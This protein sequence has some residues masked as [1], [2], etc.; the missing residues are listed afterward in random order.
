VP[1]LVRAMLRPVRGAIGMVMRESAL[2]GAR[3]TASTAAP[4]LLTIAFA[5]FIAGNVQTTTEAFASRRASLVQAGSVLVP[6]GT[7]GLSDAVARS[8][9]LPSDVYLRGTVTTALGLDPATG[10]GPARSLA[11]ADSAV[12]AESLA[13]RW[14]VHAGDTIEV[15]FAD[16][17]RV[18]LRITAVVPPGGVPAELM[19]N[20][21]AVRR[22][23]PSA[24]A[25]VVPLADDGSPAA[26]IGAR[27]TATA[28]YARQADAE[29]DRL[30]WI[31]TLLLVAV[32]VGYGGLAVANTLFMATARRAPDYRLLRLAG[33]TPRQVLLAVAGESALA[34]SVG[35]VL[36][37]AAA[38]L[39]LWGSMAGLRAQAG[40]EVPLTVPWS[41]AA[42][43]IA[44]CLL[45]ALA[46]SVL[47][48]RAHLSG[49]A[50]REA[51]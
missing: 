9:P 23:D 26:G 1:P 11:S 37:G 17:A 29:E 51:A 2:T 15:T 16:G 32:S 45:L 30:V 33:A 46:G 14:R 25:R 12:V 7:P 24:L 13:S 41:T 48:A 6:D 40:A 21:A 42:A 49:A 3:R 36:G 38:I 27:V 4:V 31:F 19:L 8:A 34:V 28:T 47:P 44:A 50:R 39:A 5:V 22:H 18:P 20:R 10:G 35:A 43:S